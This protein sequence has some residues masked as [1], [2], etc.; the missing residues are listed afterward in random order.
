MII[1][2]TMSVSADHTNQ[3]KTE[4]NQTTE[5]SS[6]ATDSFDG[7]SQPSN[8]TEEEKT[9]TVNKIISIM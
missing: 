1:Y 5:Q 9:R 3:P 7:Y 2:F 8:E 4:I 6:N